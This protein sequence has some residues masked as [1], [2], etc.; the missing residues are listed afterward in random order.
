MAYSEMDAY[1]GKL[2]NRAVRKWYKYQ[3]EQIPNRIDRSGSLEEQARQAFELRNQH[4]TQ[5]RDLMRDQEAR[6][7]LDRTDPNKTFEEMLAGEM[8]GKNLSRE[9]A[10]QDILDTAQKTRKSVDRSLGLE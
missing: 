1:H 5:A 4:R 10:Y 8:K 6:R 2:S 3:D 9:E 7:Q